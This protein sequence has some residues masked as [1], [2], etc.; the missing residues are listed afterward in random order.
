MLRHSIMCREATNAITLPLLLPATS[1]EHDP[2]TEAPVEDVAQRA[3]EL[4]EFKRMKL[5][6][7]I[8]IT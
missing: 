1:S 3:R 2:V 8:Q 6:S 5:V 7:K 4:N